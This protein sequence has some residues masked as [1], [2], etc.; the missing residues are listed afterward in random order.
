MEN[1]LN[2]WEIMAIHEGYSPTKAPKFEQM[3]E[4]QQS[5]KAA[6]VL[7]F[8]RDGAHNKALDVD[9]RQVDKSRG[10]IKLVDFTD[11]AI[12]AIDSA[13]RYAPDHGDLRTMRSFFD[14]I[15]Q[16]KKS[17]Q[18]VYKDDDKLGIMAYQSIATT[19]LYGT[20]VVIAAYVEVSAAQSRA[21]SGVNVTIRPSSGDIF[22]VKSASRYLKLMNEGTL[23]RVLT[24]KPL[25][26]GFFDSAE[27]LFKKI[28]N[29]SAGRTI[30]IGG[31]AIA[32]IF[33]TVYVV[34]ESIYYFYSTRKRMAREIAVVGQF[35]EINAAMQEQSNP[36][37]AKRQEK[38]AEKFRKL[39]SMIDVKRAASERISEKAIEDDVRR[40]FTA[41][42]STAAAGSSRSVLS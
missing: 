19:F 27:D 24:R 4:E 33:A 21:G 20:A 8:M 10:D 11:D 15:V 28:V 25:Q 40:D 35:L 34:R 14:Q 3:N 17:F 36:K 39:A 22:V 42:G 30:L 13:L 6:S 18:E 26:E 9:F 23:D 41:A 38:L 1:L 37:V 29:S 32:A 5:E 7:A 16:H 2:P 31:L 12:E